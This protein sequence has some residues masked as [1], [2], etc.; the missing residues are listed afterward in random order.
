M[1]SNFDLLLADVQQA[2][3]SFNNDPAI[4]KTPFGTV[5]TSIQGGLQE[6]TAADQSCRSGDTMG[7][8]AAVLRGIGSLSAALALAGPAG[9]VAGA[10]MAAITSIISAILEA[11]K[12]ATDS[13]ESKLEK[14]I[15]AQELKN[16]H[17]SLVGGKQAL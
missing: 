12:P 13:L 8:S 1:A 7:G 16:T 15:V 10:L 14:I 11:M 3:D 9:A 5:D 6:F 4:Q 17:A 2:V